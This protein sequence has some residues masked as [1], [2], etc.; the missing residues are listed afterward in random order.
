MYTGNDEKTILTQKR[1]CL[2][3]EFKAVPVGDITEISSHRVDIMDGLTETVTL[4][5][6]AK[7]AVTAGSDTGVGRLL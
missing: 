5:Y 1:L 4:V 2:G 3:G 6:G 7:F